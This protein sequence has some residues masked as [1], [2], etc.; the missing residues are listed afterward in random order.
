MKPYVGLFSFA[1]KHKALVNA[2][3]IASDCA[4][5]VSKPMVGQFFFRKTTT[6]RPLDHSFVLVK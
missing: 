1:Q 4:G 5:C 6:I 3:L 2:W